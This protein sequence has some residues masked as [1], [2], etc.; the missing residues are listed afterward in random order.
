MRLHRGADEH[1]RY[2]VAAPHRK[3]DR[4]KYRDSRGRVAASRRDHTHTYTLGR[5]RWCASRITQCA[6]NESSR[7]YC[8][9]DTTGATLLV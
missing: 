3:S 2:S 1:K 6:C 7:I 8:G 4:C 9:L 5:R